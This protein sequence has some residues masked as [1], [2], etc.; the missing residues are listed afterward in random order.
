MSPIRLLRPALAVAAVAALAGGPLLATHKTSTTEVVVR[1]ATAS[2]RA[3]ARTV[4]GSGQQLTAGQ[5]LTNPKADERLVVWPDGDFILYWGVATPVW[6]SRRP[7]PGATGGRLVMQPDGNLVSLV[8]LHVLW[9]TR[10]WGHP[11]ARLVLQDNGN[12]TLVDGTT[13]LWATG[14]RPAPAPQSETPSFPLVPADPPTGP[15]NPLGDPSGNWTPSQTFD[16]TCTGVVTST[17][18]LDACN[19]IALAEI[20]AARHAEGIAPM[21]L[22]ADF[23]TE[24]PAD[25]AVTVINAERTARGLAPATQVAT[26]NNYALAGAEHDTDPGFPDGVGGAGSVWAGGYATPLAAD[27]GWMYDDGPGGPNIDCTPTD[28]RGCWGHRNVLLSELSPDVEIGTAVTSDN[29][30]PS[31][32]AV[33]IQPTPAS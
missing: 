21:T 28:H 23:D 7:L 5:E 18:A 16:D 14:T 12:L 22:P 33:L 13:T 31:I 27:F 11:G 30:S 4:L 32:A 6:N 15:A 24:T 29:G 10:T 3:P 1:A 25:Q 9:E 8:G 19:Q 20:N 17:A 26:L 2:F